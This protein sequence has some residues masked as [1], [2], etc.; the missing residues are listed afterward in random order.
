MMDC[1]LNASPEVR[2]TLRRVI[3]A[4]KPIEPNTLGAE[5]KKGI[6]P[7]V[8]QDITR[9][10]KGNL[11]KL[12]FTIEAKGGGKKRIVGSTKETIDWWLNLGKALGAKMDGDAVILT[13]R[14]VAFGV[15]R[16]FKGKEAFSELALLPQIPDIEDIRSFVNLFPHPYRGSISEL[17]VAHY[18]NMSNW[19]YYHLDKLAD[20]DPE[21][22]FTNNFR[23]GLR[24]LLEELG[25]AVEVHP[26]D[27]IAEV[28]RSIT[29]NLNAIYH[30]SG[31]GENLT[32]QDRLEALQEAVRGLQ[33]LPPETLDVQ[34]QTQ[35][36]K[37]VRMGL[38]MAFGREN[39]S[40]PTLYDM[41]ANRVNPAEVED[42]KTV[43]AYHKIRSLLYPEA[44]TPSVDEAA[45][46]APETPVEETKKIRKRTEGRKR[47]AKKAAET[48]QIEK[49]LEELREIKELSKQTEETEKRMKGRKG[50]GASQLSFQFDE[51]PE[52]FPERPLTEKELQRNLAEDIIRAS[53][54]PDEINEAINHLRK[55]GI[56]IPEGASKAEAM[57]AIQK[58]FEGGGDLKPPIS[59][60][61]SPTPVI[62]HGSG[63]KPP[64]DGEAGRFALP[65]PSPRPELGMAPFEQEVA[66][67]LGSWI[68]EWVAK[69]E[70]MA[71]YL[72]ETILRASSKNITYREAEKTATLL[73]QPYQSS[74]SREVY[75]NRILNHPA[76]EVVEDETGVRVRFNQAW[77]GAE[78]ERL[79]RENPFLLLLNNRTRRGYVAWR[80][81]L[82]AIS[83][84]DA[85]M[86]ETFDS[87]MA[88]RMLIN[89]AME[90]LEETV[91]LIAAHLGQNELLDWM[92]KIDPTL[93]PRLED[94]LVEATQYSLYMDLI[95]QL[96]QQNKVIFLGRGENEWL[97]WDEWEAMTPEAKKAFV[98]ELKTNE[99]LQDAFLNN[100]GFVEDGRRL[101]KE[102]LQ[103]GAIRE[104]VA[105]KAFL[106]N[107]AVLEK[108]LRYSDRFGVDPMTLTTM[109]KILYEHAVQMI[110]LLDGVGLS[111]TEVP[112]LTPKGLG[113]DAIRSMMEQLRD[114]Y[115]AK[116]KRG[117]EVYNLLEDLLT[118]EGQT[119]L[120]GIEAYKALTTGVSPYLKEAFGEAWTLAVN[121]VFVADRLFHRG[122]MMNLAEVI[123][124][125][126]S[127]LSR[128]R[129]LVDENGQT[130]YYRLMPEIFSLVP[131]EASPVAFGALLEKT[132][133]Q[134]KERFFEAIAPF[135]P[136]EWQS[137]YYAY[138]RSGEAG[139]FDIYVP[140]IVAD[141]L[142][143]DEFSMKHPL[144]VM[145]DLFK[146]LLVVYN[147]AAQFR[148]FLTNMMLMGHITE[149]GTYRNFRM[150]IRAMREVKKGSLFYDQLKVLDP[151]LD[152]MLVH[153]MPKGAEILYLTYNP[154]Q[155]LFKRIAN[156]KALR[157]FHKA[158]GHAEAISKYAALRAYLE[159]KYGAQWASKYTTDDLL[160]ALTKINEFLVDY[161]TIPPAI[162]Y[163]RNKI[164]LFPFITFNYTIVSSFLRN[165]TSLGIEGI[166]TIRIMDVASRIAEGFGLKEVPSENALLYEYQKRNP[167]VQTWRTED[168][169]LITMDF[170]F[171]LPM[172]VFAPV[173]SGA[174]ATG[175]T[176]KVLTFVGDVAQQM[177]SVLRPIIE[178]A[179]N[180]N[181]LTGMPIYNEYDPPE[182]KAQKIGAYL[183]NIAPL[184]RQGIEAL[185]EAGFVSPE[186]LTIPSK[187]KAP[188]VEGDGILHKMG[189]YFL[190]LLSMRGFAFQEVQVQQL[191][192]LQAE[193]RDTVQA[194]RNLIKHPTMSSE[195]KA[196]YFRKY[197]ESLEEKRQRLQEG[198]EGY[199]MVPAYRGHW[200]PLNHEVILNYEGD[201]TIP[202]MTY[203]PPQF[204]PY[205]YTP[206]MME[207]EDEGF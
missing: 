126:F 181:F 140:K 67:A 99:A 156:S 204:E 42:K 147:P 186:F 192:R 48:G 98:D 158:M 6:T 151:A 138:K 127:Q 39:I 166:R 135:M 33:V 122:L 74:V 128:I 68:T 81:L 197:A 80:T 170:T 137:L 133:G 90:H 173:L 202:D 179:V 111:W 196:Y 38:Y 83:N 131:T 23:N 11:P 148:N 176:G 159:K 112:V 189:N 168:G 9:I 101:L 22:V 150:F 40:L 24:N 109:G 15:S 28:E 115:M 2:D 107:P 61:T 8:S 116:G 142:E 165:P 25:A 205:G 19:I 103:E 94:W 141:L 102:T 4:T 1:F 155:L 160:E 184:Y 95:E 153:E 49:E 183:G 16:N 121:Y 104:G 70:T 154:H 31:G 180:Q 89:P 87:V 188:V 185:S 125:L 120:L 200:E 194:M 113:M 139:H 91:H 130:I 56:P 177:G 82:D 41:L 12:P 62:H 92:L 96:L 174:T 65:E 47:E 66:E 191:K 162:H 114:V 85:A 60:E 32:E 190:R 37:R 20:I 35:L 54:T 161:R 77:L 78:E 206:N 123:I 44:K 17:L 198:L 144:E 105:N 108:V 182:V 14:V 132:F 187:T 118:R 55:R 117:E 207:E 53:Y 43:E 193:Y 26:A 5:I 45:L 36:Q 46:V 69:G 136:E 178:V 63:Y 163:L 167:L 73:A 71:D 57:E 129:T 152:L 72:G 79:L 52:I 29:K 157:V 18:A 124:P 164:G 34:S 13:E 3:E 21:A 10:T 171:L 88:S 195:Q 110:K 145:N 59:V 58:H 86:M 84:G 172:G 75:L 27:N 51:A 199:I 134:S 30:R 119:Q 143:M 93:L 149:E 169:R 50:K 64:T 97:S 175:I 106:Q 146:S 201:E 7:Y 100:F 76:F 203:N